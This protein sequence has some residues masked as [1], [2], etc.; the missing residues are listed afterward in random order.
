MGALTG[1]L[2]PLTGATLRYALSQNKRVVC[3]ATK[4]PLKVF[5]GG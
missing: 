4:A 5:R 2:E 1:Q 3:A